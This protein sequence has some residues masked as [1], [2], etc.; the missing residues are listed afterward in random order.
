[1]DKVFLVG[2]LLRPLINELLYGGLCNPRWRYMQLTFVRSSTLYLEIFSDDHCFHISHRDFVMGWVCYER[3]EF[4]GG[5]TQLIF[6][7]SL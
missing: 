3:F 2:R 7:R 1:M 4:F 6:G 5:N